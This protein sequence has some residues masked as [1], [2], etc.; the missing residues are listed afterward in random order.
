M[1]IRNNLFLSFAAALAIGSAPS[2]QAAALTWSGGNGT[3][4]VGNAGQWGAAWA[5][6]DTATFS[7]PGG[8]VTLGGAITTGNAALAFPTGN[9][10][11]SAAAAQAV[12]IGNSSITIGN[13]V[14]TT[15]G[16]NATINRSNA[17]ILD[18][19]SDETSTFTLAGGKLDGITANA[20]TIRETTVNVNT[21]G[22][23]ENGTSVIVGDTAD[24][25]T[26]NVAGGTVNIET[27]GANLIF[28]N[29]AVTATV[30]MTLSSGAITFTNSGNTGGLRYGGNATGNTTG[31]FNLDG[32]TLTVN[33]VYKATGGTI[34]STFNFNGGTLKALRDN[35]DFMTGL[36]NAV[37]KSLG[38]VIDTNGKSVTLGQALTA[39]SPSGGLTK[40]GLGTLTLSG[41]STYTGETSVAAGRLSLTGSLDSN[42]SV[43]ANATLGGEGSA[44]GTTSFAASGSSFAFDPA[45]PGAFTASSLNLGSSVIQLASDSA[46]TAGNTY[47]VMTNNAGFSGSPL[48]N[49]R[50]P[51]R[52]TLAYVGNNLNF[53]FNAPASIKWKGND[54]TNPTFW[55]VETSVNWDNG[56][57]ADRFFP[58]DDVIFDD[59]ASSFTV[60]IQGAA[61]RPNSVT[62][63]NSSTY[64]LTGGAIEGTLGITKNGAG[65]V[66]LGNANTYTGTTAINGGTIQVSG[67]SAIS[68]SGL[69]S[70]AD[71]SGAVLQVVGSE[72]I[73]AISGG[74]ASGGNVSID[75]GQTLTLSS[76]NQTHAGS[77]GGAGSLAIAG[78][79]Q[80]LGGV[81]SNSGG[82]TVSGGRVTLGANNTYGGA[83]SVAANS[84][85]IISH[86]NGLGAI[87]TGNETTIAGVGSAASG[88]IGLS[89]GIT[90]AAEKIIGSGVGHVTP[91]TVDGFTAQQRGIVQSVS[92][93][94]TFAGNIEINSGGITRFGT[95]DGAQLTLSGNI[96]RSIGVTGIQLLFRAGSVSGDFVTLTSAGHDFDECFVFSAA[97]SGNAGL[98]LGV[99]N[100]LPAASTIMG[101]GSA[102]AATSFD[103]N[104]YDQTING[105]KSQVGGEG[106]FQ[107][108]NL[109]TGNP[110][111]LTLANTLDRSTSLAAISSNGGSGGVVNIVKTGTFTQG[112]G[113]TNTNT[114]TF[115]IQGG[116]LDFLKLVSLYNNDPLS[117]TPAN[118]SVNSGAVLGLFVGGTGEFTGADVETIITNLTSVS[119]NGLKAGSSLGLNVTLD[120]TVG[121]PLTDSTGTGGGAVGLVKSGAGKLTMGAANTNSG[122][123]TINAGTLQLDAPNG[124]NQGSTVSI[125]TAASLELNFTGTDTVD[126]LFINGVQQAAGVY[127]AVDSLETGSPIAQIT[128]TGTLTVTSG[129]SGYLTWANAN[130]SGQT[131]DLDHDNDG[132]L[133][134][135][136]YFMGETGSSFT[137]NPAPVGGAI[138]WPMAATYSGTYGVNYEI[139]TSSDLATWS[140]ATVG[141]GPGSVQI[142]AGT[143]VSYTLPTGTAPHFVRMVVYPD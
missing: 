111:T 15:L 31:I 123:T 41:A 88:Q 7:G 119:N 60:A 70:L 50:S 133:N 25:A 55:D 80:T 128:G 16:A 78:A 5:N 53:T 67:G 134:G 30:T 100:A 42:I 129:P 1:K 64:T 83:T 28:N 115:S 37:V 51:A 10:T 35:T 114:G 101:G 24:G 52:G 139:Q 125:A 12:T 105:L 6:N 9:Y 97:P 47:L 49:F 103:L 99:D 54:G 3:W 138:T 93:N 140:D 136:E 131:A 127:K 73:G 14:T 143:S 71:V 4:Q 124:S 91:A 69:V 39:G 107:I 85:I 77:V 26:L 23:L 98:R 121:I 137:A 18:G 112:L 108:V 61:V 20:S 87:G 89:G 102:T 81:V 118:I 68:N 44:N 130:A 29:A 17:W 43:L 56:G 90:T 113:A 106:P 36:S 59:T 38:A 11:I 142:V 132:A 32:G 63:N 75:A 58:V 95:Q 135:V 94:N 13:G 62:F 120:S 45:T 126:K 109:D 46:M 79:V 86:A 141:V 84:G 110:S 34:N 117:W 72:T 65:T 104:G 76:G 19:N 122:N 8:T 92:G 27:A 33:K 96:T 21:G 48:T 74:G 116:R 22:V 66:S 82:L 40:N 57:A 2:A